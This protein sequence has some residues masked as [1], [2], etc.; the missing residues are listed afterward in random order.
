MF[1]EECAWPLTSGSTPFSGARTH[2][3]ESHARC[4]IEW[5]TCSLDCSSDKPRLTWREITESHDDSLVCVGYS[6]LAEWECLAL[7]DSLKIA[8][9][10]QSQPPAHEPSTRDVDDQSVSTTTVTSH[11][12]VSSF[13]TTER[14]SRNRPSL[15]ASSLHGSTAD[16][17]S[18]FSHLQDIFRPLGPVSLLILRKLI[19][20]N[21]R[22]AAVEEYTTTLDFRPLSPC[23]SEFATTETESSIG[24]WV[25]SSDT[26]K[27]HLFEADKESKWLTERMIDENE[28]AFQFSSPVMA[29]HFRI[30]EENEGS[31]NCLAVACQDGTI[32]I[33]T[34]EYES[35]MFTNVRHCQVIV[36]GPIVCID[37][38]LSERPS[39]TALQVV[40]GSLCGYA[41]ELYVDPHT[42]ECDGPYMVAEGF[43]NDAVKAEDSVLAVH[44]SKDVV[45]VGTHSGRL[46]VYGAGSFKEGSN[47][48]DYR[49]LWKCQLPYSVHGLC[50]LKDTDKILVTTRRSLH[51][52][53]MNEN[54]DHKRKAAFIKEKIL[55]Q[56]KATATEVSQNKDEATFER[57]DEGSSTLSLTT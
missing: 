8:P 6:A 18:S 48:R 51:V 20:D 15:D 30:V 7:L 21:G 12:R 14:D 45:S 39:G 31:R 57:G 23:L 13:D 56:I 36:D 53:K 29:I 55:R 41:T 9:Q 26:V 50:W 19:S 32:R 24:V 34:F 46:L 22:D 4:A 10:S 43:W 33:I 2:S 38:F 37:I 16:V 17:A 52:F 27:L 1:S 28:T 40:A 35:G 49:L 44:T 42:C 11:S 3:S 54:V 5:H 47:S 25:G